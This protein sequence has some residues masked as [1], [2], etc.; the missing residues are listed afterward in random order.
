M[1]GSMPDKLEPRQPRAT[2]TNAEAA[3]KAHIERA[4]EDSIRAAGQTSRWVWS[5]VLVG[6][7]AYLTGSSIEAG[8]F[9]ARPQIARVIF[10][11]QPSDGLDRDMF[12]KAF[13]GIRCE[14]G[15]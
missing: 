9:I 4:L 2:Q 6:P 15:L 7:R 3:V 14:M 12:N 10:A 8:V 11:F 13:A 5:I 1:G